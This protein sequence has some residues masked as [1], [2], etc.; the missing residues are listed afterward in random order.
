MSE[1]K[2]ERLATV[3]A[4]FDDEEVDQADE[5]WRACL[6]AAEAGGPSTEHAIRMIDVF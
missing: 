5:R 3:C 1:I 4:R 2:Q 6:A